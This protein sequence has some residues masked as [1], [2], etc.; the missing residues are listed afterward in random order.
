[1][2]L[3]RTTL[4]ALLVA[5]AAQAQDTRAADKA[6]KA[7]KAVKIEKADKAD[8]AYDADPADR[9][10][11]DDEQLAIAAL[12][13]LM[14]QPPERSL[15]ILK[16]VLAGSQPAV[17]KRRAIFVLSQVNSPEARAL[18]L[19]TARTDGALRGDAIRSIGISGDG[20][21]LDDLQELYAA[22]D[23]GTKKQ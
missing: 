21:L 15:P 4:L 6:H 13:G 9:A 12:E 1:M 7:D 23:A 20:K 16:R 14:T 8:K 17:V 2:K 10:P 19:Q 11:S 5:S 18:L 22:S 3:I